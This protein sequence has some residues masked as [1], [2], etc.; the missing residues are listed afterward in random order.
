MQLWIIYSF[1]AFIG[2][3]GIT[4]SIK[5]LTQYNIHTTIINFWFFLF[6]S[7]CFLLLSLA[8]KKEVLTVPK[9]S[10]SLF[11]ILTASAVLGNYFSV[12][13]YATA[14][15]PGYPYAIISCTVIVL[16]ITSF[17]LFG[18]SLSPIKILGI[19][20]CLVGASLITFTS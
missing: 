16:S 18:S 4:L 6:S 3:S 17:F 2:F 5:A 11:V 15:N 10:I 19:V 13:A 14:P 20:L 12:K 9:Q 7:L 8:E 1:L